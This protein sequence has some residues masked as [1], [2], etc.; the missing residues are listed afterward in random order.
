MRTRSERSD[1]STFSPPRSATRCCGGGTP[2][3]V[4]VPPA[5]LPELFAAQ[6]AKTPDAVAVVFEDQSLS[7]GELDARANQL[8]HH[9]RGLGVGPE[10]VVGLCVERSLE[11]IVGLLGILK[12]GGAYLPLDPDY[13]PERLAFML[14]DAG[15]PV[16]VT[17]SALRDRLPRARRRASCASMPTG[18]PSHASPPPRRPSHPR[19]HNTAY[20]IYTSGSTGTPKGVVVTHGGIPNFCSAAQIDS[21]AITQRARLLQFASPSFDAA[22]RDLATGL[23]LRVLLDHP[24]GTE[25]SELAR[26]QSSSGDVQHVTHVDLAA[27]APERICNDDLAA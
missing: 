17:Q 1:G 18:P 12:A 14:D 21:F 16:L 26:W 6:V 22:S 8:A 15:A 11:M 7:Y 25:R 5:T 23:C 13:P 24:A 9:L 3:R 19:P 20:V 10:T 2:P 4:R 27:G